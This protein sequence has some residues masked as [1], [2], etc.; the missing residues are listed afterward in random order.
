MWPELFT[1]LWVQVKGLLFGSLGNT[2]VQSYC[3]EIQFYLHQHKGCQ[4]ILQIHCWWWNTG[5]VC[6]YKAR[7]NDSGSAQGYSGSAL[8]SGCC[9][10]THIRYYS[11]ATETH[12][13]KWD[14]EHMF[15]RFHW[16]TRENQKECQLWTREPAQ[17]SSS[18]IMKMDWHSSQC[19]A[20]E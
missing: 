16:L 18:Q 20:G 8:T 14:K 3:R 2:Q 6:C 7:Q 17:W 12:S 11:R 10:R 1:G 9:I 4:S 13:S 19:N 15:L 5:K